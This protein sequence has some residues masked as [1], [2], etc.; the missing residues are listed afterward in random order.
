MNY[1]WYTYWNLSPHGNNYPYSIVY[2]L[3]VTF[4]RWSILKFKFLCK[5]STSLI[6]QNLYKWCMLLKHIRQ[7]EKKLWYWL[8]IGSLRIFHKV[9]NIIPNCWA[10]LF[11]NVYKSTIVRSLRNWRKNEGKNSSF[12]VFINRQTLIF[13]LNFSVK[14]YILNSMQ[15]R[16]YKLYIKN[17]DDFFCN[18]AFITLYFFCSFYIIS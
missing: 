10:Y 4:N 11:I 9:R 1:F 17:L 2:A 8:W 14:L 5:L 12:E 18:K 13:I 7:Y 15:L 16:K 6:L 3:L